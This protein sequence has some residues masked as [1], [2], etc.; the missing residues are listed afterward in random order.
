VTC[1]PRAIPQYTIGHA[2]RIRDAQTAEAA[3]PGLFLCASY[4]GGVAVADCIECAFRT[5]DLT[6]AHFGRTHVS[7]P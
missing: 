7:R 5:A 2:E 1:W 4:R 3:L 6:A